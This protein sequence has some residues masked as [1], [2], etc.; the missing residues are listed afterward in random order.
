MHILIINHIEFDSTYGAATSLRK[1]IELFKQKDKSNNYN[2]TIINRVSFK[3]LFFN[4]RKNEQIERTYNINL[5]NYW[6][7]PF[8]ENFDAG[9]NKI[10]KKN[11]YIFFKHFLSKCIYKYFL[12]NTCNLILEKNVSVVHLNSSVLIKIPNDIKSKL[13]NTSPI[14]ILHI[15]DFLKNNLSQIQINRFNVIDNFVC[16]DLSTYNRLVSVLGQ[17]EKNKSVIV[18]NL[19][20]KTSNKKLFKIDIPLNFQNSTKYLIV[21]RISKLKGVKFVLNTFLKSKI[22]N[23]VLIIVGNGDGEYFD[24]VY[25]TCMNNKKNVLLL[26]EINNLSE[27]DLYLNADYLVRGDESFRTGRT[28]YEALSYHIKIILPGHISDLESDLDLK[29]FEDDI[30]FFNPNS[31]ESLID[32]FNQTSIENSSFS[33]NSEKIFEAKTEEYFVNFSN[34]YNNKQLI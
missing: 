33:S 25:N 6:G 8:E 22:K 5:K 34:L 24:Q 20:S 16:I 29:L 15:R 11:V 13:K 4:S 23:A 14:F 19:F 10:S 3:K 7:L 18:Q 28:V 12:I 1:H 27:S 21:G 30:L 9:D 17:N 2:F 32:I 31:E 26:N